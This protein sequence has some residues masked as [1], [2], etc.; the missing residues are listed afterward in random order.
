VKC[1][2]VGYSATQKG[3]VC[4]SP[5]E[6]RLFVSMDV[7]FRELEPYY[8]TQVASSFGDSLDTGG[9]RREGEDDSSSE[10][11]M[12]SVGDIPCPLVE[13]AEVPDHGRTEPENGGT[14]AQGEL[15]V[16]T[17]RRKQNE[18]AVQNEEAVPTVPLVPSHLSLP[19]LTPETP[20]PSTSDSEYTCD[21]IH[22]SPPP[23]PLSIRRTSRSN[24]GVLPDRYGF[25]HDIAQFVS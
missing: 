8:S 11:R 23:T 5:I 22:L 21:M 4:W 25:P 1:V 12:V 19:P 24:V 20:T 7:T 18:K 15:R 14:Q 2:F 6:R 3:Y 16:Y 10:R 13:S 17:R 9:M